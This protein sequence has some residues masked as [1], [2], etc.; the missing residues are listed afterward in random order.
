MI[1]SIKTSIRAE[2]EATKTAFHAL[3]AELDPLDWHLPSSNPA[4]TVGEL[5][6]HITIASEFMPIDLKLIRSG[7]SYPPFPVALFDKFNGLW[8]RWQARKHNKQTVADKFDRQHEELLVLLDTVG[9][10]E[11]GR[12]MQYPDV[13]PHLA[14]FV[15]V[16]DLFRYHTHHFEQH[17]KDVRAGLDN[18]RIAADGQT[19]TPEPFQQVEQ[20]FMTYPDEGWRQVMFKAPVHLFRMGLA[21]LIGKIMM[22]ITHTGRK[23]GLPRRTMVEYHKLN[24]AKYVPVAFGRKAQWYKNIEADPHVTIQTADGIES[25]QAVRVT[26]GRELLTVYNLFA[27]RDPPLLRWYLT[28]LG[29][30]PDDPRDVLGKKDRIHWLRFDPLEAP[31][32]AP[33]E[34]DLKWVLPAVAAGLVGGWLFLRRKK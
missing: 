1:E 14:G 10:D 16:E 27:R 6:F 26:E 34:A 25:M 22:L 21:P 28:S 3:L 29:I 13:D 17:A 15:T 33:M 5:I 19:A 20:G 9:E 7:R 8:T 4:W 23:S 30:D 11:W 2:M 32:P 18:L 12:G 24:G 31:T